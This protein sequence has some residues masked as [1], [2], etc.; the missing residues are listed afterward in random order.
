MLIE[1]QTVCVMDA[2]WKR[3]DSSN[4][5]K[6]YGIS[7]SDMYQ[8]YAYGHKYLKKEKHKKL[9]LIY[10]KTEKFQKPLKVF[11]YEENFELTVV[12]FDLDKGNLVDFSI[13]L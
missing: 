12:P 6:R 13:N 4:R 3:I 11:K 8:L 9:V 7:Q 1:E 5:E 10:P 2:K